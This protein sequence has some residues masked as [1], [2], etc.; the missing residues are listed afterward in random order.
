MTLDLDAQPS[1]EKLF[2]RVLREEAVLPELKCILVGPAEDWEEFLQQIESDAPSDGFAR[3]IRKIIERRLPETF[4]SVT[5]YHAC[6][7]YGWSTY[8]VEGIRPS[9]LRD[10][11]ETARDHF[12]LSEGVGRVLQSIDPEYLRHSEGRIG[13][14]FSGEFAIQNKCQHFRGSELLRTIAR[15]LEQEKESLIASL[16]A[17]ALI[18]CEISLDHLDP[19]V[20]IQYFLKALLLWLVNS[21]R[22]FSAPYS[23]RGGFMFSGEIAPSDIRRVRLIEEPIDFQ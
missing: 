12:G 11:L 8:S 10:L 18:Q 22:S 23:K 2:T 20:R 3:R 7:V 13:L 17:P 1:W 21:F 14:L 19:E 6:R 15:R 4:D 5:A 9:K 16:G